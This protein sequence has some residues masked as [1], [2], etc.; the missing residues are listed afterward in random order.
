[1]EYL[2]LIYIV[3]AIWCL[4]SSTIFATIVNH[5]SG[6]KVKVKHL[7][8]CGIL[9]AIPFVNLPVAIITTIFDVVVGFDEYALPWLRKLGNKE[10]W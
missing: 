6:G 7:A 1:M 8:L 5:E 4:I 9:S 2:L 3:A 10:L